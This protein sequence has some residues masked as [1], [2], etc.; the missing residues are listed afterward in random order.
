MKF[1]L[2]RLLS[3]GAALAFAFGIQAWAVSS[4]N[5]YDARLVVLAF[6][7]ITLAVSLNIINGITGQF[8]IGHAAFYMI[9]AYSAGFITNTHFANSGLPPVLWLIAMAVVGA[10]CAAIAGLIVGL[11]SLR[12]RGDYLAIVTLGFGEIVRIVVQNQEAVGGPYGLKIRPQFNFLWVIVMLAIIAIAVSRNLLKTAQGLSFLAVREDEVASSAM[13][14]NVTQVKVIA[15]LLGSG[16][17]GAA[18]A[19]YALFDTFITP[20]TFSMAESFMILTMVVLGG[21]GSITGSA[22]AAVTLFVLPELLRK[23]PDVTG[24]QVTAGVLAAFLLVAA[25]RWISTSFH[26]AMP[27]RLALYGGALGGTVALQFALAAAFSMIPAIAERSYKA[28]DLR[29]PIFAITLVGVM[30]IRPQGVFAH[31]EFSWNWLFGLFRR[32]RRKEAAPV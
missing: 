2:V 3:I 25:I 7:Y 4:L 12:L 28:A 32:F 17:A 21:S 15:F 14:V 31:H 22:L 5:D 18:G 29:W 24:A 11:P 27:R 23:A 16:F 13:G 8:S 10:F 20:T 1:W 30:L 26:G 19:C 6:L 9:G